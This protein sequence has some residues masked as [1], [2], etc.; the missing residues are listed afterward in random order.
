ML[1]VV[2][3]AFIWTMVLMNFF[4][5]FLFTLYDTHKLIYLFCLPPPLRIQRMASS[6]KI[7]VGWCFV[8][9]QYLSRVDDILHLFTVYTIQYY[10]L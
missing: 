3:Y 8:R 4:T 2:L 6:N 5:Y 1:V 7:N 9:I 10:P